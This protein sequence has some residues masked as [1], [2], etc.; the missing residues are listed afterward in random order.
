MNRKFMKGW[1]D[2]KKHK[3]KITS[4]EVMSSAI[5]TFGLHLGKSIDTY[6]KNLS[7][8]CNHTLQDIEKE[9]K[10]PDLEVKTYYI[11]KN[12]IF[13]AD[14]RTRAIYN[15]THK[16]IDEKEYLN[17]CNM[18]ISNIMKKFANDMGF[19]KVTFEEF[20]NLA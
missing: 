9:M 20:Y 19:K 16:L 6:N 11:D 13:D 15:M 3:Y 14:R 17:K 2:C 8:M 7:L 4:F 1:G 10:N 18:P 5:A 12:D